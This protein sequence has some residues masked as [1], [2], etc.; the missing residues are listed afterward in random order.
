MDSFAYIF[1]L[2][3]LKASRGAKQ[4]GVCM[5][6][7]AQVLIEHGL[8]VLLFESRLILKFTRAQ[9]HFHSNVEFSKGATQPN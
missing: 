5:C 6:M 2:F 1:F 9:N 4:G 7:R 8:Q 3:C